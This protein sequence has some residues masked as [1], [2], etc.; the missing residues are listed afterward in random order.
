MMP[1]PPP[2]ARQFQY[3]QIAPPKAIG[4]VPRYV[5][6]WVSGF[7]GR[8]L[9][10]FK[11]VWRTGPWI[12]FVMLLIALLEGLLPVVGAL[13]VEAVFEREGRLPERPLYPLDRELTAHG[14]TLCEKGKELFVSGKLQA[15]EFARSARSSSPSASCRVLKHSVSR[16]TG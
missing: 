8:M 13:G 10:I 9:Y 11:L 14:M 4:D 1:G 16:K 5:K 6:E 12:L 2:G 3:E 15:G 7:F